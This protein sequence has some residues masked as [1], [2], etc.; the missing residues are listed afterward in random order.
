[1][2]RHTSFRIG[3]PADA[4][5]RPRTPEELGRLLPALQTEGIPWFVLGDGANILVSDRG[6]RGVV[7]DLTGL[8]GVQR[9]EP[10]GQH[11]ALE[12][13]AGTP[14]SDVSEFAAGQALSGLEFI[15]SMPGS[16]GGSVWMNARCYERSVC[17]ALREVQYL[18]PD[19]VRANLQVD[20]AQ[21]DQS[22]SGAGQT[23]VS[24][25]PAAWGYKLS[26]FQGRPWVILKAVFAL[27]PADPQAVRAQMS[28]VRE[29]RE[30]KGHFLHPSAGSVFKNSRS[31]GAPTGKLIDSLGLKGRQMGG[32]RISD[33]HGNIIVNMG[34]ATAR[35]VLALM[36]LVELRVEQAYGHRP[37][38]EILLVGDWQGEQTG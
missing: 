3:G 30:R 7:L 33:L 12:A 13:W 24:G 2:S 26:P 17:E 34:G 27:S 32:A 29:D 31:F 4:L 11:A 19:G 6:I 10:R 16:V 18:L 36:R 35:D 38:R 25:Q 15:Y 21:G 5:V 22:S 37:E 1:M 8:R 14:M 23:G 9:A 20:E 28:R